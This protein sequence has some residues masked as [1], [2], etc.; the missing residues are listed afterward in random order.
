[1]MLQA[2]DRFV[3]SYEGADEQARGKMVEELL[4]II[5]ELHFFLTVPGAAQTST[6]DDVI[7]RAGKVIRDE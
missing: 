7:T 6:M 4:T 1:M 3:R 5:A 2:A